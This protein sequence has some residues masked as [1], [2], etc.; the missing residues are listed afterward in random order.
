M[1]RSFFCQAEDCIRGLVRSRGLGDVYQRP[2]VI[3][4]D[5]ASSAELEAEEYVNVKFLKN[6]YTACV[7][8]TV[9]QNTDGTYVQL[10]FTNSM[11]TFAT[12][13]YIDLE[14]LYNR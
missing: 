6:Q 10:D 14:I 3:P 7:K 8:V 5:A 11:I 4:V 2:I 12:E 9:L 1:S 13:R